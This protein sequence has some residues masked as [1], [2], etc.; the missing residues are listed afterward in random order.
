MVHRPES[1]L[2]MTL[3][4]WDFGGQEVYRV[5]HQFF[6][7]RGALYVIVWNARQGHEQDEVEGWL[8]R[9]RLRVGPDARTLVVATHCAERLPEL[10]YP[11]LEKTFPE[12]LNG[13]FAI[14]SSTGM[15]LPELREAIGR[16]AMLL[17]Q[18]GQLISPRWI[19]AREQILARAQVDPQIRY[20]EFVEICSR[21]RVAS[22]EA[23]AL[24]DWMH[25]LGQIVYYSEDEGLRD[26]VVLNP[27]W[28]T[29]AIS[30]VLEDKTTRDAA[31]V[32]DHGRLREIWQD[33]EQETVYPARYHRYFL[34]LMEKFDVSYR[35][36]DD[37]LHSIVA[38]LV[39][40]ER[41]VLPWESD[42]QLP[43]GVRSLALVCRLSEPTLGLVQWLTVRH[44]RAS[45]GRH[46]RRGIF[47]RHP[48][49]AYASEALV[50]LRSPS[51]LALEVR[52]PSPDLFF[53]VLRDSVED[54]IARRWP[55]L[56]YKLLIPCPVK[57][58][59]TAGCAGLF[60]LDGLLRLR[61][62]GM[63]TVPC[64][65]CAQVHELSL[66]LTGFALP[67]QP[68]KA[69]LS[70]MHDQL[71]RIESGLDRV[72]GQ[73]AEAAD[74]VRRVLRVVSAEVTDCPRLFTITRE[75]AAGGKRLNI[76]QQHY[77][78]TLWCEH[79]AYWHAW[80][81]ARYSL[82]PPKDWFA[83]IS[84]YAALVFKTLQL[85]VP[86]AGAVGDVL[87][88]SDQFAQARSELE[89]MS[90]IVADLPTGLPKDS[91]AVGLIERDDGT[92]TAAEGQALRMIRVVLFE[93]DHLR[94]FG[95][96]RRV[97]APSGDFLWVCPEHYSEYDPGLPKV[98]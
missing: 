70:Q 78:I 95:G 96:M 7:S 10:D 61:E 81:S 42:T 36:E 32:L 25:S 58:T 18:M 80:E 77:R 51:E 4:A 8:R 12:M 46:W 40:H 31:G 41:P 53:N 59:E 23:N 91:D 45:T 6:F 60:P 20:E 93:R 50:E 68:L 74:S 49:A 69:E 2:D 21:E 35:L 30:Y 62:R 15:G 44:H 88:S 84:P 56:T 26:I 85:V 54:L 75:R 87:L 33:R 38:Q 57:I 37:E 67:G 47:L 27:E 63:T 11:H 16:Q 72:E 22:Q 48:I 19:A 13:S 82:S 29:K 86:L 3:R 73:A 14:D 43:P 79:S 98:P 71:A 24:A 5:T 17:P 28:L 83:Q 90:K 34:R 55:G 9:I 52:A 65:E 64:M 39:P 66:L 97:Q 92:L 76:F 1:D 94:A 89:L